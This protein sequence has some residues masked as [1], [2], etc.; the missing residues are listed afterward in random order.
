LE[1]AEQVLLYPLPPA[2][3][4]KHTTAGVP[5]FSF[6]YS[7]LIPLW[8]SASRH[9]LVI[10]TTLAAILKKFRKKIEAHL[11]HGEHYESIKEGYCHKENVAVL[12]RSILTATILLMLITFL[13]LALPT[14][15]GPRV[16][17]FT[18]GSPLYFADGRWLVSD[19]RPFVEGGRVYVPLRAVVR[20]LG[21]SDSNIA[22]GRGQVS[23]IRNGQ[24]VTLYQEG[25]AGAG[26]QVV[27]PGRVVVPVG[28]VG[29]LLNCD[30]HWDPKTRTVTLTGLGTS[31]E[32]SVQKQDTENAKIEKSF[33]W[34][35]GNLKYTWDIAVDKEFYD[36]YR[37]LPRR[38]EVVSGDTLATAQA[39]L[40]E[41]QNQFY[42]PYVTEEGNT[43]LMASLAPKIIPVDTA[44]SEYDKAQLVVSFVQEAIPYVNDKPGVEFPK[45]PVETL[46]EGGDCE[47][48]AI[49]A[50]AL[51]RQLGYKTL[52]LRFQDH[53]AI[54][55]AVPCTRGTYFEFAGEKYWFAE[56]SNK[57][58]LI[59][60]LSDRG[61]HKAYLYP[62]PLPQ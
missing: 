24:R 32:R 52:L 55:V 61:Y 39:K 23:I 31:T 10:L 44:L 11:I 8:L 35:A 2:C 56:V 51:L 42:V 25:K 40:D 20:A 5:N 47:D 48:K 60:E 14:A 28:V 43:K 7:I 62:V 4:Y 46:I 59:G 49:L 58:W 17:L 30:V 27:P 37:N 9:F 13:C 6:H 50:A 29:R 1:L 41:Y 34:S 19:A 22:W 54:A 18:V 16:A 15:A 38:H 53:A 21:V 57:T 3:L 45:Y 12:R 36:Y 26:F 33:S